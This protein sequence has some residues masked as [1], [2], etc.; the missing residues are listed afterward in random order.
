MYAFTHGQTLCLVYEDFY[1]AIGFTFY[2][3]IK[4][5]SFVI[6][7]ATLYI[8]IMDR[9][10]IIFLLAAASIFIVAVLMHFAG[11]RS[12]AS[13]PG[14]KTAK[15]ESLIRSQEVHLYFGDPGNSF[16]NAETRRLIHSS[17]PAESGENILKMLIQ[18]PGPGLMRTIPPE[19]RVTALYITED[20]TAYVDLSKEVSDN[21]PGG[22][23]TELL[24]IYSIVNSLVLNIPEIKKVKIL[25]AG[26]EAVTLA[27]HVGL[28][29]C[30]K[31]DM[32][33]IR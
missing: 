6:L 12:R 20:A 30:F 16:L 3:Y 4:I 28:R 19:T 13:T 33:L 27:G 25:I 11:S 21:H 1:L 26:R 9:R 8:D 14:E 31:A 32:L 5:K 10:K 24:T 15:N 29:P 22:V 18:G 23:I 2:E 17:D 7:Y